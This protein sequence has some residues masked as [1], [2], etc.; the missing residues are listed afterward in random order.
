[1]KKEIIKGYKVDNFILDDLFVFTKNH[2]SFLL[3]K[4]G[5]SIIVNDSLLKD[6]KNKNL[7]EDLRIKL[8]SHALG[9]LSNKDFINKKEDN[10]IYFIIDVTK[11]CNFDCI[12]CFRNLNDNRMIE[13]N[14]LE[15]ICK[16][17]LKVSNERKLSNINLQVWGGEPIF[18]IKKLEYIYNFF[19]DTNVKVRIDIET[20][21]SLITDKLA[22]R[23]HDMNVSI[24]VSIDGTPKHQNYQRK[25]IGDKPS[26][27]LVRKGIKNLQKYYKEDIGGITVVTKHNYK[28]IGEIIDFYTKELN[29][30][31]MK[32]NLVKD[33]PNADEKG[34]GLNKAKLLT[35]L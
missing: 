34:I 28:D 14:K 22:K 19:K 21:G 31:N 3:N 32:F 9:K 12:Y 24:G 35:L 1:M 10:N 2:Y 18:G 4:N 29:I 5:C 23:L 13:D 11:K 33:N 16:Y 7:D 25:L 15:D 30:H 26:M 20:N 17:I 8:L 6:I 27:D